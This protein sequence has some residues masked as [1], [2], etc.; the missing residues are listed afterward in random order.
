MRNPRSRPLL[1]LL[2]AT[3]A[4]SAGCGKDG[5]ELMGVWQVTS[6]TLNEAGCTAEGPA[7]EAGPRFVK[8]IRGEFFG[9]DYLEY[10]ECPDATGAACD[11]GGNI[12]GLLYAEPIDGG[13]LAEAYGASGSADNCLYSSTE[14]RAVAPDSMLRIETRRNRQDDVTGTACDLDEAEA[15]KNTLPCAELEILIGERP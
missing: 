2:A 6:H 11:D 15:R 13:M 7:V 12:F 3:A 8:F 4:G 5:E 1:A 14:S 9:Q 10:V